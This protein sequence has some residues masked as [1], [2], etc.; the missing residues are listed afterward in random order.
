MLRKVCFLQRK[1][2]L[3]FYKTVYD[4]VTSLFAAL[5]VSTV[6]F[7]GVYPFVG[8]LPQ[9]YQAA[10]S[11][12]GPGHGCPEAMRLWLGQASGQG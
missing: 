1:F 2:L 6:S 7:I 11:A 4:N 12:F 10:E 5:H 3:L 8:H 9:G